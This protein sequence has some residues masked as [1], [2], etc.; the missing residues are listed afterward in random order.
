[1]TTLWVR[2]KHLRCRCP[3]IRPDS[4]YLILDTEGDGSDGGGGGDGR[5]RRS[6]RSGLVVKRKTLVL[7]WKR[8]WRRRM[9]RFKKRA[10]KAC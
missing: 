5:V 9:K 7:Q 3:K 4:S 6:R 2:T 1:M 8:E 10:R